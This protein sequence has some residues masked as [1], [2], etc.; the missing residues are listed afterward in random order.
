MTQC[1]QMDKIIPYQ[2]QLAKAA[3]Q[4]DENAL[5]IFT[6]NHSHFIGYGT[7]YR[8]NLAKGMEH[9]KRLVKESENAQLIKSGVIE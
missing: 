9:A 4:G 7:N 6:V 5:R 1:L 8:P 3:V 2:L